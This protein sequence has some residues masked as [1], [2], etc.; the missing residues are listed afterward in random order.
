ML[1]VEG[2]QGLGAGGCFSR[3]RGVAGM[4]HR[5]EDGKRTW[6]AANPGQLLLLLLIRPVSWDKSPFRASIFPRVELGFMGPEADTMW[7]PSSSRRIKTLITKLQGFGRG[8]C[9]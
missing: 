8:P 6:E 4:D 7:E 2:S 9:K 3:P 1:E 5:M